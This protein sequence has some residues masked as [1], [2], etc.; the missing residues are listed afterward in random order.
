MIECIETGDEMKNAWFKLAVAFL[1]IVSGFGC[2]NV[3]G[4]SNPAPTVQT[5][6]T[7]QGSWAGTTSEGLAVS[8]AV[9]GNTVTDFKIDMMQSVNGAPAVQR[10][11][12][13]NETADISDNSFAIKVYLT[14]PV[15]GGITVPV[16]PQVNGSF[17]S[18]TA[19]EGVTVS[20]AGVT[21]K[22][23]KK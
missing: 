19:A 20:T 7:F 4:P 1:F 15:E 23:E 12:F 21:W 9:T 14:A 2:G 16:G 11:Y 17:P 8:F 10:T 6:T 13:S 3:A 22:A 5:V 18:M